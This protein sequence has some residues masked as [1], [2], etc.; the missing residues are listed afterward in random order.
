MEGGVE[1]LLLGGA[2]LP[3][4]DRRALASHCAAVAQHMSSIARLFD[5]A[6]KAASDK[7][8]KK[9]AFAHFSAFF[10]ARACGGGN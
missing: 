1:D 7:K 6:A 2:A 8:G 9:G 4:L 5:P 10:S 3:E